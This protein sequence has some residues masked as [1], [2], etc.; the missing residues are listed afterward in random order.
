MTVDKTTAFVD[1]L[2]DHL[3]TA[4]VWTKKEYREIVTSRYLA[5]LNNDDDL[6]CDLNWLQTYLR[7]ALIKQ[8]LHLKKNLDKR[9]SADTCINY[10][11]LC[12]VIGMVDIYLMEEEEGK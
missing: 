5:Q 7:P 6:D 10:H 12:K 11:T 1:N 2:I 3:H 8:A 9:F 4:K